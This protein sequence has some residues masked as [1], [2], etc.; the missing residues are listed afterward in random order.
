[1][2]NQ[3]PPTIKQI[4]NSI[5]ECNNFTL[6]FHNIVHSGKAG[7]YS[8]DHERLHIPYH[9]LG[10]LVPDV[11]YLFLLAAYPTPFRQQA[12]LNS[13]NL[14]WSLKIQTEDKHICHWSH[15]TR[16]T[17]CPW[18][19]QQRDQANSRMGISFQDLSHASHGYAGLE[20]QQEATEL[21][22]SL[23]SLVTQGQSQI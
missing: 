6:L 10:R 13:V 2:N 16:W 15:V 19:Y 4:F 20:S 18:R 17:P 22:A 8:L 12:T 11:P 5:K 1:M 21:E 14:K 9:K 23:H 3:P 7:E